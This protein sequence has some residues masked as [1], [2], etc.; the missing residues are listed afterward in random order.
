MSIYAMIHVKKSVLLRQSEATIKIKREL[1]GNK[2]L[3]VKVELPKSRT[4]IRN[5]V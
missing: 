4:E 2:E 1:C 3:R 5:L